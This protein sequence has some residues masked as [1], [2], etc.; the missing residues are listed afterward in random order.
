M[1][2][3]ILKLFGFIQERQPLQDE[4]LYPRIEPVEGFNEW[5][6]SVLNRR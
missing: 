1:K 5:S 6:N 3:W 2:R 4:D